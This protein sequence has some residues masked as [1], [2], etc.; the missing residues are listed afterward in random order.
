MQLDPILRLA[1]AIVHVDRCERDLRE[2]FE[3]DGFLSEICKDSLL[4]HVLDLSL[5]FG[6][7]ERGVEE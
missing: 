4:A 5:R 6:G 7:R 1:R 2:A 3:A